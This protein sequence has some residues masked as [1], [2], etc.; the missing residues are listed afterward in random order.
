MKTPHR[1]ADLLAAIQ[2]LGTYEYASRELGKWVERF[3]RAPNSAR[4]WREV[5]EAHPEFFTID[6][7]NRVSMVWRRSFNS[8][9]DTK[10]K[11]VVSG[12]KLE[13]LKKRDK[14]HPQ[15][16]ILSREPLSNSQIEHL[17]NMAINLHE[18]EIQHRQEIRWW[19]A[20]VGAIFTAFVAI[21]S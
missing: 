8:D 9:Y 12:K 11:K 5:F 18:R 20:G 6:K 16:R 7:E 17:C 2:V 4:D 14:E 21:I 3:G 19:L 15:D 13:D 10:S 1:L